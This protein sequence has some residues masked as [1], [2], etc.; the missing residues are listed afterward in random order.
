MT[1]CLENYDLS[2]INRENNFP[3]GVLRPRHQYLSTG[4]VQQ[5]GFN[6]GFVYG[7]P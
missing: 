1:E 3:A 6:G 7:Q 4:F 2:L 5:T